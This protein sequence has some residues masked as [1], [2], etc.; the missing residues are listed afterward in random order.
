MASTVLNGYGGT[1]KRSIEVPIRTEGEV[2]EVLCDDLPDNTPELTDIFLK[3]NVGILH[4]RTLAVSL[5]YVLLY[6]FFNCD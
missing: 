2:L 6:Y 1:P 5:F 3:E 4:Y